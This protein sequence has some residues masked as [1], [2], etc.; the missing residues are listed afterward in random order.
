MK[1]MPVF[2]LVA[3]LSLSLILGG[4]GG[5]KQ[6]QQQQSSGSSTSTAQVQ[7]L[8]FASAYMETHPTVVNAFKPWLKSVEEQ[9]GGKVKFNFYNQGA[10]CPDKDVFDSV[11]SGMVDI[12]GSYC[13]YYPGKFPLNEVME[14][15]LI[16]PGAEAGSLVTWEL[17]KKYP[18]WQKEFE[19]VKVLWQWTSATYQL[20]TTKKM[21]KTL[22]DLKGMKIIGW[23]PKILEII[24]SLGANPIEVS[25]TDTYLALQRGMA[26]GVMCPLA[27][28]KSYKISD[29]AK[30][31]TIV[32]VCVGPFFMVMNKE[33]FAGLPADVQK[34]IDQTTG[35]KMAQLCGKT[36]DEG[37]VND[38]KWLKDNGHEFYVLP[39]NERARWFEAVKPIH[40]KWVKDM[41]AKGY[42][43][44]REVLN[45]A[46]RLGEEFAK[47]TGRGYRE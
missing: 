13:G 14:L 36:L 27:P 28:L 21:V 30:Y 33:K 42:T 11:V 45:E 24:R 18:E 44:A 10:L 25:A 26:D 20:H 19:G 5:G 1:K 38:S 16:V 34:V 12:G 3:V 23:S 15:P 17:Y 47:K 39:E 37:A 31:H 32:D 2:I 8:N 22:E 29:A 6:Q 9:S 46:I 43:K 4:C 35:E 7:E 40:E 41:E